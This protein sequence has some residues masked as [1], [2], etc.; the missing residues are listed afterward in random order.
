MVAC[1]KDKDEMTVSDHPELI[2]QL[3]VVPAGS[4]IRGSVY[5]L[6]I[7]RPMDTIY[8]DTAFYMGATEVTNLE[9]CEFLNQASI[10]LTGFMFTD[11]GER[12]LLQASDTSRDGRF[13]QG[14]IHTGSS[15]QPVS[16]YEYYPAIYISWYGA[17]EYCKWKGGRLP[18]EAEW[19]YAAGN[20]LLEHMKYGMT[21]NYH[22][23][24]KYAWYN[25]NS[26][27][28]SKP[29]GN[30]D[31][32]GLG[33]YDMLGNVNE[34]CNDWF[35]K[36]YYQTSRDSLWFYDPQGPDSISVVYN[37]SLSSPDYYPY[38][39]GSR[40][41]FRGGSYAEIRTSGTEGTHRV[42]YRGH[43]NPF[44]SWNTYG[45]RIVMDTNK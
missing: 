11:F 34:W 39:K 4:F 35:G 45:F 17:Y 10:P 19:E 40:K 43:M 3:V 14:I 9:Y 7:E 41:I 27:G 1:E 42:T 26:G 36:V 25:E 2:G 30:K 32:N 15:W 6:N 13:N 23:L 5:G 28:Q 33:L 21:D 37:K 20:A 8:L 12:Q 18:T 29:V 22:E 16:G 44:I 31:P 24:G 38:I